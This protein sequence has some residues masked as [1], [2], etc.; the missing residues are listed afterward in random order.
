M[1]DGDED[2][3]KE[4]ALQ[5]AAMNPTYLHV[6]DVPAEHKEKLTAEFKEEMADS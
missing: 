6:D 4:V 3:A 5:V 2:R 1:Y